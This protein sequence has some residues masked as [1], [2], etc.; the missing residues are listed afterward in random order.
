VAPAPGSLLA[1]L[2]GEETLNVN[3]THHQAVRAP[4]RAAV[5]GRAPDGVVEAIEVESLPF[6]LGVQWHPEAVCAHEPRH[7]R[8]CAGLVAAAGRKR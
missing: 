6:A 5:T 2:V 7:E 1:R 4:G 3:S 8:I